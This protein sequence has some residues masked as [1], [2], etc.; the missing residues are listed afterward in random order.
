MCRARWA[1]CKHALDL[2]DSGPLGGRLCTNFGSR[3]ADPARNCDLSAVIAMAADS[4]D[5]AGF[6]MRSS[7]EQIHNEGMLRRS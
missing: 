7:R 2:E 6:A 3:T 4:V 5:C 1:H